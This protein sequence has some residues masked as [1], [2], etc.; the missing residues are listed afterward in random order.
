MPLGTLRI[1]KP[2]SLISSSPSDKT[3]RRVA[4]KKVRIGYYFLRLGCFR[5]AAVK[6]FSIASCKFAFANVGNVQKT[7]IKV[8][9]KNDKVK[10]CFF[11]PEQLHAK[12]KPWSGVRF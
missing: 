11:L 5:K 3:S 6:V 10:K 9:K 7:L 2:L 1:A 4:L 8:L 12:N